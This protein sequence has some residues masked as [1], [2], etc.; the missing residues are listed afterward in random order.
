MNSKREYSFDILRVISMCMVIIIHVSNVYSRSFGIISNKSF[1]FSL[2]FNTISRISVP[3][4]LMISGALLLERNFNKRKYL[5]RIKKFIILTIIW[6]IIYLIWEYFYLGITYTNYYKLLLGP[7]RA[8]L[9][10]LYTILIIYII[11]PLLKIILEKTN[12]IIKVLLFVLW[13]LFSM[14]S[15]KFSF[16]ASYFTIF[17]YI[18]YFIIGNY[19]YKYLKK[20]DLKKYTL[21]LSILIVICCG[22]SVLLNYYFSIKY[23]LFYNL[24]FAY[25]IPFIIIAT[26]SFFSIIVSNYNNKKISNFIIFLSDL[27][28]GVYLIHGIFLDITVKSFIYGTINSLIGI[29]L[30][31]IIILISSSAS[32]FI[33]RKTKYIKKIVE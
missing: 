4:F 6:D 21:P 30:F 3:I 29:P 17:C 25:R 5:N 31:F 26:F 14:L 13:L 9:W 28:F 24:F 19:L 32:V 12:I 8:H 11:Q 16:I 33:L 7:F 1:L 23:N 10:Y 20:N 18:G 22:I 15:I 2:I 27:S